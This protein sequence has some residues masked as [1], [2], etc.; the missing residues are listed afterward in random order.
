MRGVGL[1]LQLYNGLLQEKGNDAF[2][3]HVLIHVLEQLN[4]E[5]LPK[6][7]PPEPKKDPLELREQDLRKI[8]DAVGAK[9]RDHGMSTTKLWSALD[10]DANGNLTEQ[11]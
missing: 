8:K 9:L 6:L 4:N 5:E 7:D 11:R 1:A 2:G 10:T 3:M